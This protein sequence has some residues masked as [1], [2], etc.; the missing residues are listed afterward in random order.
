MF[1]LPEGTINYR[2]KDIPHWARDA[3]AAGINSVLIS[4]WHV[5]GHDNGY[6]DYSPEPR[7][8]TWKELEE[9][10]KACHKLGLRVYFFVKVRC[11][12]RNGAR[13]NP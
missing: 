1:E 6:P 7:L 13:V 12:S 9:G 4:G 5:G 8:G 11:I 10:I 3:K 2:F